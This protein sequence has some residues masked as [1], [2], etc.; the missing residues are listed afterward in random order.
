M[1]ELPFF[2][3]ATD[4]YLAD[5]AH[6]SDAEHGRY[7]LLLMALWRAPNQRLPNDDEWLARR[8]ARSAERIASEIR[9]LIKEF[10]KCT[11]NW[12]T[13]KRL[14]KEFDY[15]MSS[16][17]KQSARAKS[18]WNKR[19]DESHGNAERQDSGNAPYSH[20][21][22][23]TPIKAPVAKATGERAAKCGTR[24]PPNWRPNDAGRAYA[25]ER[26]LD[27]DSTADA[28]IDWWS[29]ANGPNAI[30]RDWDAAFRTWCRRDAA[31]PLVQAAN[32]AV[33]PARGGGAY[34]EQLAAIASRDDADEFDRR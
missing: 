3:L 26:G 19:K 11:G 18:G 34:L 17:K 29:A 23:P 20:P 4:A 10:C 21:T 25:A 14:S 28:F 27:P 7:L 31:G 15:V 16:R 22:P 2:P 24:I 13:Q 9:P 8:F 6:L 5:C 32:R 1:A 12:I 33:Q 30:K